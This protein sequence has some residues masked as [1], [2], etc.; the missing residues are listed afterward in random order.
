MHEGTVQ[1]HLGCGSSLWI[2]CNFLTWGVDQEI[3]KKEFITIDKV[4]ISSAPTLWGMRMIG[5]D[6]GR[7]QGGWALH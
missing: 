4:K 5:D 1:S 3:Y 6:D 2:L 7:G